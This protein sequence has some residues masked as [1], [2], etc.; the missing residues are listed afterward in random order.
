LA[1]LR[2]RY[3][4]YNPVWISAMTGEGLDDLKERLILE[5]G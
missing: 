2:R 1:E 3:A 5:I 4:V